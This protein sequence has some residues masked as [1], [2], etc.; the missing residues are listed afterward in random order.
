MILRT[1]ES[2]DKNMW[3]HFFSANFLCD[4]LETTSLNRGKL[5]LEV[6]LTFFDLS[7]H[8]CCDLVSVFHSGL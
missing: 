2:I 8:V 3:V 5:G 6:V 4:L 1:R 7:L